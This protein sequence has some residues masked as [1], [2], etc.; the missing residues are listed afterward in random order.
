MV[1][2]VGFDVVWML[3]RMEVGMQCNGWNCHRLRLVEMEVMI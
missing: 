2:L 3:V 1:E